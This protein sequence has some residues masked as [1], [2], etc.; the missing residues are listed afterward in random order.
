MA[1]KHEK[2]ARWQRACILRHVTRQFKAMGPNEENCMF[3]G[4][5]G[6]VLHV[7]NQRDYIT[8]ELPPPIAAAVASE[9]SPVYRRASRTCATIHVIL[10]LGI[11]SQDCAIYTS[12]DWASTTTCT[13]L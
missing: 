2:M 12:I 10:L 4:A 13:K 1:S 11:C 6:A 3:V 9:V 5:Q 7:A 8:T